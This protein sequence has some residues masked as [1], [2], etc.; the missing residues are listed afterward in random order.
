M[1][2]LFRFVA[3]PTRCG[4][5]SDRCWSLEY[6]YVAQLTRAEYL[7]L[8]LAGWR[9]FGR[10]LFR[11]ACRGCQACQAL[12][13]QAPRFTPDRSQ[14]RCRQLNAGAIELRIGEPAV[15]RDKL[16][17]YDRYHAHQAETRGWP[18][19]PPRDASR[20]AES[21]VEQPFAVEEWCYYLDGR[22][23]GVGYVDCLPGPEGGLSAIY[24]YYDP[25]QRQRA[26]GTWN[27][28]CLIEQAAQ[29]GLPFVYLGYFVEG[30]PSMTYKQRFHP[31]QLRG[32]D[33]AWR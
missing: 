17:L 2:S 13:V 28:L 19:H 5:L 27:I 29:R 25:E 16:A 18:E 31:H 30:C 1:Q 12:R 20:Y 8:M 3:E 26:P 11:P 14:R 32:P 10:M 7:R 21:F 15:S 23:L 4:Y 24:F 22:L 9:R 6:D 33:G